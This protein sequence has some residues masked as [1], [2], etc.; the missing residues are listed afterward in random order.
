MKPNLSR[1]L[2]T[3]LGAMALLITSAQAAKVD[4]AM[5][6]STE[7][8]IKGIDT[9]TKDQKVELGTTLENMMAAF[10]GESNAQAKYTAYAK[11][12]DEEGYGQVASLFRAA[13]TAEGIH[14]ANHAEV[15]KA[16][17]GKPKAD[18]KKYEPKTTRENLVDAYRGET[19]ERLKMYPAFYE[20]ARKEANVHAIRSLNY[21]QT[22]EEGH[23]KLYKAAL[24]NLDNLKGSA[25]VDFYVCPTCGWT[26]TADDYDFKKCPVCFTDAETFKKVN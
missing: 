2:L 8:M 24:M 25:N 5:S 11:K 19:Y 12:A 9:E 18:V 13:A 4:D 1:M 15:I 21:A 10:N 26:V 14:A 23:A 3:V 17:G 20:Q 22:A 16:M 6:S 7:E